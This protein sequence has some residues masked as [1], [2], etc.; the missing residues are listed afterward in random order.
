MSIVIGGGGGGATWRC[1][2]A[3]LTR[4]R[5]Q[6]ILLAIVVAL[7]GTVVL[8]ATAGARRTAS[9]FDR[10]TET[11]RAYDVL[12]FFRE[13][14][15]TTVADV[16]ELAGVE[17]AGLV[18]ALAVQFEDGGFVA[19][20]GPLD[21][22]I[23]RDI[24]RT[25]IVAG[26]D[27][28]PGA[29]DE[30]VIGE[31]LARQRGIEVGDTLTITS[32]TQEQIEA[33]VGPVGTPIPDPAGPRVPLKVVGISRSPVDLSQ[34]GESGGILLF[35]RAFTQT[36]GDRVGSYIKVLLVRLTD[37]SDGVP[38]FVR[39]LRRTADASDALIDEVEPTA[40]STT[41][42]REAIDV[43][44]TGLAV[45]AGVAAISTVVICAFVV[46]RL[47]A[48]GSADR[49][50]WQALGLTRRQRA[51]ALALPS[52]VAVVSGAALAVLGAWL[53][54]PL[55]PIGLARRAE[56]SPGLDLDAPTLVAGAGL[57]AV[58]L[59]SAALLVSWRQ[60]RRAPRAEPERP[61]ALGRAFESVD[62]AP[63][64]VI[65]LRAALEPRRG[66]R[67]VPVRSTLVAVTAAVLGLVAVSVFR[68]SLDRLA[69]RPVLFGVGWEVAVDDN[70]A[71]R[72]DPERP[73]S[74]LSDS[75]VADDPGVDAVAGVCNLIVEVEGHPIAAFG[76]MPLRGSVEPTVLEG[77]VPRGDDEIALGGSTFETV[78]RDIGE[79]VSVE[80]PG[81]T[82]RLRIVGQVALPSLGESQA[83]ADGAV[84]TGAGLD[85]L[86]D[87]SAQLSHAW[88]VATVA[89]DAD[90]R[91]VER[92][93][94]DLPDV[95]D[96][97][98]AGVE[99]PRLP[100]EVKRLQQVDALPLLLAGF[101]ALLGAAAIGY[102]L[103]TSV[104]RRHGEFAVLRTLG[105]TRRQLAAT[106]AWQA[107]T[108]AVVGLAL[109]IPLGIVI[110]RQVWRAVAENTGVAFS[111]AVSMPVLRGA[112]LG[113][114]LFANVAAVLAARA[115]VRRSPAT[116]LRTE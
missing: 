19:A 68:P 32:Y 69:S 46:A 57:L 25:R 59:G 13:L 20:G 15:P 67:A 43:L 82:A 5:G 54:S 64:L 34:Q 36:Y 14:G 39:D 107:T 65:G 45:F 75:R 2:R 61:S 16:Q 23:F 94:T 28:A 62:A 66:R 81:G 31:P 72:P 108:V 26:R 53:A 105:F 52:L 8:A 7:A 60:A 99:T 89:D 55:T 86:D 71:R 103:V 85:R 42:A 115:A 116:A 78:G 17:A 41:G 4:R 102:T 92:R 33:L 22:V 37:G 9:S 12:V 80:G 29:P 111:A 90:P 18:D 101:L 3:T 104:R 27:T 44:G 100:L 51:L 58:L 88:V 97:E 95:G 87:P 38:A 11:T 77:R 49:D 21:D 1:G 56:P 112:A 106:V 6:V 110:G 76:Y 114:L 79:Q 96:P 24:A 50:T 63:P 83:V 98:T 30:I 113:V 47:V 73:C 40:V 74:G 109:G 48:L 35:P 84:L 10:F 93:L 91:A 70:L